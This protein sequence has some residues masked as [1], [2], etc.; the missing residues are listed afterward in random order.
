MLSPP[1]LII[2]II[3]LLNVLFFYPN[4]SKHTFSTFIT[5]KQRNQQDVQLKPIMTHKCRGL[6]ELGN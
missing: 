3:C 4:I 1:S 5:E 6:L 2:P